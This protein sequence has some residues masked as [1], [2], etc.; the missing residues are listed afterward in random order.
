[1]GRLVYSP[2]YLSKKSIKRNGIQI[3]L[4]FKEITNEEEFKNYLNLSNLHYR[5]S[6]VYGRTSRIIVLNFDSLYPRVIGYIEIGSSLFMNKPRSQILNTHY[7]ERT[8]EWNGWDMNTAKTNINSII[9]I[10][11]C[12][13]LPE[14]RGIGI[15][16]KLV[17]CAIEFAQTH[18]QI[19]GRIPSFLEISADMLKFVP[20]AQKAG[21]VFIGETEGNLGR[22]AR[23]MQYLVENEKRIKGKEIIK[24][25]N[26]VLDQQLKRMNK[27]MKI[28]S[29]K[30]YSLTELLEKI[31][32]SSDHAILRDFDLFREILSFPKPTFMIGLNSTAQNFLISRTMKIE[33]KHKIDISAIR[34]YPMDEPLVINNINLSIE[35]SVRRTQKSNAIHQAFGIS[36]S[37]L[38]FNI[39]KN[40]SLA[41]NPKEIVLLIGPSGS[42]K[43]SLLNILL[44]KTNVLGITFPQNYKPSTFKVINSKKSLIEQFKDLN[45][46]TALYLM[47]LVG[48]SDAFIYL[49]RFNELSAGQQ[50]RFM[51]TNLIASKSNFWIIDEFCTNLD[52]LT[53]NALAAGIRKIA[54][55][56]GVT[57]VLATPRYD[58][59]INS[60]KPDKIVKMTSTGETSITKWNEFDKVT[61]VEDYK[62]EVPSLKVNKECFENIRNNKKFTTNRK[63]KHKIKIG[64]LLLESGK[65]IILVSV[66][67]VIYKKFS[68]LTEIDAIKGGFNNVSEQKDNLLLIYPNIK[69]NSNITIIEFELLTHNSQIH[70]KTDDTFEIRGK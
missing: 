18:W 57:L 8:I 64:Y 39:I 63:G 20:F 36:P 69:Q 2:P 66:T 21:M 49:K 32:N 55:T 16:K 12:V 43:T 22:V 62:S 24:G 53:A 17:E 23:D 56:L 52:P 1:M 46:D 7:K 50:Y 19:G 67:N 38:K 65:N 9:R 59:F 28:M 48:L 54:K 3:E 44:R 47:G 41:I 11:R 60:L 4:L 10:S 37:N 27:F 15:G 14:F 26:G 29:E 31:K 13:I 51:V 58:H 68:D 6:S 34:V 30:D 42:G 5:G 45:V 70:R 61:T 25:G 40:F 35:S 33:Y